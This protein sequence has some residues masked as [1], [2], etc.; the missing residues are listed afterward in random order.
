MT[1]EFVLQNCQ[2]ELVTQLITIWTCVFNSLNME[3]DTPHLTM[4]SSAR[5]LEVTLLEMMVK[6]ALL[7]QVITMVIL[8]EQRQSTCIFLFIAAWQLMKAL[9]VHDLRARRYPALT[10]LIMNST[11]AMTTFS[12]FNWPV[13][14]LEGDYCENTVGV[15][16]QRSAAAG[17]KSEAQGKSC[18]HLQFS[19]GLI[20]T[21]S[22]EKLMEVAIPNQ[23]CQ[24]K[25]KQL[26]LNQCQL[27]SV[28]KFVR[29]WILVL[30]PSLQGLKATTVI[31]LM[32]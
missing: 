13:T 29:R 21:F 25:L 9:G 1:T 17:A 19:V 24:T 3:E 32:I 11:A 16:C 14:R 15:V 27:G 6:V 8:F 7:G 30:D 31:V 10:E 2:Q 4:K 5:F 28:F 23:V 26:P 22:V 20:F 18:S 12:S